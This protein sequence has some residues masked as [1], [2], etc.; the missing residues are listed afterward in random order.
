MPH[1]SIGSISHGKDRDMAKLYRDDDGL[2]PSWA[3]PG[4]YPI[5]YLVSDGE[6]LCPNCANGK[7][8]SAASEA[9][10]APHDWRIIA[11]HI[12]YEGEPEYCA[13]CN[14]EIPSAYG[15]I[16]ADA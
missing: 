3:W 8:G 15:A 10:D 5:V 13:H 6:F 7:N 9:K 12:H 1:P 16:D 4:G 14:A 11:A 2:L